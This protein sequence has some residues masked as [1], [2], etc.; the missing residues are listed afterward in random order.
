MAKTRKPKTK[1]GKR[2]TASANESD[3]FDYDS[4][5]KAIIEQMAETEKMAVLALQSELPQRRQ[6]TDQ[7]RKK[8]RKNG[9][10]KRYPKET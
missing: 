7:K 1:S 8:R 5:T 6:T 9:S 2:C 3:S 4:M 10:A